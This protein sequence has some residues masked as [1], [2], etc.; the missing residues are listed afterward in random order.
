MKKSDRNSV[1]DLIKFFSA[2]LIAFLHFSLIFDPFPEFSRFRSAYIL[3]EV[4][5]IITGY[6]TAKHFAKKRKAASIDA[7]AK[8][9]IEYV[10]KKFL[11][12]IPFAL[13]GILIGVVSNVIAG[14][15]FT[16]R[17]FYDELIKIPMEL[18][19]FSFTKV[20]SN[21]FYSGQLW[22]LTAL[23]MA[24]PIFAFIS[25]SKKKHL[26]NLLLAIF[27]CVYYCGIWYPDGAG[28]CGIFRVFAGLCLGQLIFSA[29]EAL[30]KKK[31]KKS[32]KII[33]QITE[34]SLLIWFL[35]QIANH[36]NVLDPNLDRPTAIAV[37][38]AFFAYFTILFSNQTY[39]KK[40]KA[41]KFTTFLGALSMSI[42]FTHQQLF[43]LLKNLNLGLSYKRILLLSF[44]LMFVV[45]IV[46][47]FVIYKIETRNKH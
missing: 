26:R 11:P 20:E 23:F 29:S 24:F 17:A 45:A 43:G 15:S 44:V 27:V 22:Y 33:L 3:V 8:A 4:F 41:T 42:F 1:V 37:M 40:L 25:Y 39:V 21:I 32:T 12:L 7:T 13:I 9:I 2:V 38:T 34:T 30:R 18:I 47:Y 16:P 35:L 28:F 14:G 19:G 6:F 10:K 46:A 31:L 5:L 36:N